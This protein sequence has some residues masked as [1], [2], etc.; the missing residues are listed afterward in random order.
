MLR[1]SAWEKSGVKDGRVVQVVRRMRGGGRHKDK[2]SEAEKKK[3]VS[4][5]REEQKGA[6]ET[7]SNE[8]PA[9][10]GYQEP[11]DPRVS[12]GGKRQ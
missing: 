2:K 7:K 12:G 9:T 4:A 3:A 11:G 10:E 5:K 6:E 8:G 1:R